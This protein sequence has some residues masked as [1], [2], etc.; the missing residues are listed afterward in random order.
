MTPEQHGMIVSFSEFVLDADRRLLLRGDDPV[1]LEPKA[2]ELLSLLVSRHPAAISK[3]SIHEALWGDT[4]VSES[5]LA[6]LIADLRTALGDDHEQPRFIRTVR[7]FGYAFCATTVGDAAL[8]EERPRWTALRLGREIPLREGAHLVGRGEECAIR[9]ESVRVSRRHARLRIEGDRATIEDLGSRN[10]TWLHGRRLE[11]P[12][13]I[14]PGD[15]VMIGG[16]EISF[17]LAG[18]QVTTVAEGD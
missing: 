8:L 3:K 4:W 11:G 6:G 7:G 10:G 5:S 13:E 18:Q 12:A 1:H 16:D 9:C 2:Y 15:S 14:A 17:V